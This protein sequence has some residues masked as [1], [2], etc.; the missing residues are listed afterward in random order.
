MNPFTALIWEV[1]TDCPDFLERLRI[2]MQR[3]YKPFLSSE[4]AFRANAKALEWP[5]PRGTG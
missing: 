3:E 1:I 2:I 5:Y 4:Q